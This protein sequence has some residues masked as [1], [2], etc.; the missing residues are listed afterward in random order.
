MQ[1]DF[2]KNIALPRKHFLAI[3]RRAKNK[4]KERS[5]EEKER[6]RDDEEK[7][8]CRGRYTMKE[9]RGRREERKEETPT[10]FQCWSVNYFT[11]HFIFI[12]PL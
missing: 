8:K 4:R 12:R 3:F 1:D 6:E 7:R 10:L 9:R 5:G 11:K 2:E